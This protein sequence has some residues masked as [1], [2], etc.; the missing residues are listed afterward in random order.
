VRREQRP[1]IRGRASASRKARSRG[2]P[3]AAEDNEPKARIAE[4]AATLESQTNRQWI[5]GL[6]FWAQSGR[7]GTLPIGF[8]FPRCI[9]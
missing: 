2:C 1:A 4:D 6:A 3:A 9:A 8:K 7:A 5:D